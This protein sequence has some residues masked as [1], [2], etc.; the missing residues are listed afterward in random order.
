MASIM[1]IRPPSMRLAISISPS[2]VSSSTVPISRMYMRTGSVVRPNSLSTVDRAA[3]ASS[4]ASS[5]VAPWARVVQQ[6]HLGIGRLFVHRHT[7]VVQHGDHDFHGFG[8]HQLVGQVVGDF[9]LGQVAA[10]LAQLDQGLQ[11]LAALGHVF[12]GQDGFVQAKFLHQGAFLGL[13]DLHAQGLTFSVVSGTGSPARSSSISLMSMIVGRALTTEVLGLAPALGA[14]FAGV[15]VGSALAALGGRPGFF[16]TVSMGSG[17][18]AAAFLVSLTAERCGGLDGGLGGWL[19][20]GCSLGWRLRCGHGSGFRFGLGGWRRLHGLGR[21]RGRSGRAGLRGRFGTAFRDGCGRDGL[22]GLL[23]GHGTT[24][25]HQNGQVNDRRRK[26][27][28]RVTETQADSAAL[29]SKA[30]GWANIWDAVLAVKWPVV[31]C[32][33]SVGRVR[34]CCCRSCLG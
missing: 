31:R 16:L 12:F 10:R 11:A 5:T 33:A 2:R 29:S 3:S 18:G 6:Q 34:R 24:S 27:P 26:L 20:G 21:G 15:R 22:L 8:V 25:G 7:Q 4:S 28:A 1:A 14:G 17:A 32:V 9:A 30:R 23:S 19:G 13:A